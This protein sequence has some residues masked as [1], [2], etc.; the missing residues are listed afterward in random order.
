MRPVRTTC[1]YCG[2]GCGVKATPGVG[3]VVT[4]EGDAAHPATEGRL[5][6]KGTHLGETV[7]LE[8]RLLHPAI[9]GKRASRDKALDLVARPFARTIK[10]PGHDRVD[11]Y[12]SGQLHTEASYVRNKLLQGILPQPT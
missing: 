9:G 5:C 7:G 6:S 4:I 11:F 8:G 1:P 3:R 12:S 2:V 10:H